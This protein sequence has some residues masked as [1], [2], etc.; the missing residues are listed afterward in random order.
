MKT[1]TYGDPSADIVLI[2]P[3]EKGRASA[4]EEEFELIRGMADGGFCLIGGEWYF[5]NG[6]G[7]VETRSVVY[8]YGYGLPEGRR[9]A[10]KRKEDYIRKF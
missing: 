6:N 2:Q 8:S 7:M 5:L 3:E 4:L 9:T 10:V 1:V